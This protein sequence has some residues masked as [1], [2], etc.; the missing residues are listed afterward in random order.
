MLPG[1]PRRDRGPGGRGTTTE[2]TQ[3]RS[4]GLAS[5]DPLG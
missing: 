5:D 1:D 2:A 3:R 4:E